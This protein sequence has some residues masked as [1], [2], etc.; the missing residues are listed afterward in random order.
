ME[1]NP[2]SWA[3]HNNLGHDLYAAGRPEEALVHFQEATRLRPNHA[4]VFNNM[5]ALHASA[6]RLTEAEEC[7]RKAV[8]LRPKY[9]KAH[10]GLAKT[11]AR[12]KRFD[13]AAEHFRTAMQLRPFDRAVVA[14]A[15]FGLGVHAAR[16][17]EFRDAVEHYRL[18]IQA[19]LGKTEAMNNMAWILATS[20][21]EG[22]R[23]GPEAVRLAKQCC[24]ETAYG[25]MQYVLTLATAYAEA[26]EF[27]AAV[28]TV[29]RAAALVRD[30]ERTTNMLLRLA[31]DFRQGKPYRTSVAASA[32]EE[33]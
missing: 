29:E 24:D 19:N 18:A 15:H 13:D 14:D 4:E 26:G 1:K 11:L 20:P 33:Q 32:D 25:R 6:G 12:L 28:A 5:G 31:D 27:P 2:E 10:H 3:A 16:H 22:L 23:N 8:Q 9:G 21:D 7:Y 17:G 30:D